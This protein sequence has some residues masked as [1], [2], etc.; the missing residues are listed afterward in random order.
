MS[1]YLTFSPVCA[2]KRNVGLEKII[3]CSYPT[4]ARLSNLPDMKVSRSTVKM[5]LSLPR[6]QDTDLLFR[7]NTFVDKQCELKTNCR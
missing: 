2:W 1:P 7:L 3:I 6:T 4:F 5:W